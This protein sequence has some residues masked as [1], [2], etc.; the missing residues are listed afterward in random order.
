M[1]DFEC[2]IM[3]TSSEK[4]NFDK[5]SFNAPSEGGTWWNKMLSRRK[6]L[7]NVAIA[8]GIGILAFA[9]DDDD[10]DEIET[11][12]LELQQKQGWNI[13]STDK[14]LALTDKQATDSKGGEAWK[15]YTQ[16][17][18]LMQAYQPTVGAWKPYFV[19]TLIQALAQDSLKSA[20]Q[21]VC[22]NAMKEAY[23]RGLGMRSLL[24][25]AKNQTD[26]ALVVDIA[27]PEAVAFAAAL[28]DV[29]Q[30]V[31]TFDNWPHPLGVVPSQQI[32][33]ALLYYAQEIADK[34]AVRPATAPSLF[35]LDANRLAA[36]TDADNQFDNRYMA[37]LPTADN[38]AALGVKSL[39]YAVASESQ[40]QEL[41]DLNDD[42]A[43][44]KDKG[45]NIAMLPLSRFQP[46]KDGQQ[47]ASNLASAN[48]TGSSAATLQA[49]AQPQAQNQAANQPS[50]QM[51][52][53]MQGQPQTPYY[54]QP[55]YYYGGGPSFAP[56]FF[57]H[58]AMY[59]YYRPLPVV[60][61][62]PA[63]T[64]S[65]TSY[66]PMRRPTMFS[67]NV[68]GGRAG[69]GKQ[70]PAGFGFV[71]VRVGA[72]GMV[73]GVRAGRSGSFGGSRGFRSGSFG[74]SFGGR[75]S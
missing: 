14:Q 71:G 31:L 2:L 16:P 42:F 53:Q 36:Y 11:N 69:I 18:A 68:A 6:L 50:S 21:P 44:F 28:A 34:N 35:V 52:G 57:Y 32:L 41:D 51:Q 37:K 3:S 25:E 49:Q 63:T 8:G 67:M 9:C 56:W 10:D 15:S 48:A 75:S 30:P 19:P 39:T 73:S 7:R 23:S 59:S 24:K 26:A 45:V 4:S 43:S 61:S 22:S 38:M 65:R 70:R 74:R 47:A 66:Q 40:Q 33:G 46:S 1:H 62:L 17:Q 20:I 29:V 12:A 58:Y 60:T 54:P 55:V 64:Y 5:S 72:G 27:G 13:G